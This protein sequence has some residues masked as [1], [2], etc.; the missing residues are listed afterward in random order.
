M[1]TKSIQHGFTLIELMIVVI[2]IG[3][4]ASIAYPSYVDSVRKARRGDAQAILVESANIMEQAYTEL[5][6]YDDA[7]TGLPFAQSPK[8]G[9]AYYELGFAAGRDA[10]SYTIEA[11]PIGSQANDSCRKL[12]LSNAGVKGPNNDCW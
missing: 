1:T 12:S 9:T 2:I 8:T 6:A 11:D 10:T 7:S 4:L 3:I 5:N